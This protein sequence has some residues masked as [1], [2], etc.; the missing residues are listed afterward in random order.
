MP[1]PVFATSWKSRGHESVN[2]KTLELSYVTLMYD[3]VYELA[4]RANSVERDEIRTWELINT[5]GHADQ[6]ASRV[7]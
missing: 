6:T 7:R 5:D 1:P 2:R 3:G 4:N